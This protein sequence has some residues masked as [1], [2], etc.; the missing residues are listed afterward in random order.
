MKIPHPGPAP[1]AA[2]V[3]SLTGAGVAVDCAGAP[4]A[5]GTAMEIDGRT[6]G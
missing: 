3:P 5:A 4:L 2:Q 6:C 1:G